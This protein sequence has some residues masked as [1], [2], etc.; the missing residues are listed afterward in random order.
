GRK[1]GPFVTALSAGASDM[2]G[3]LL[4]GLP[5]AMYM[6]D[7]SGSWLAIGLTTGAF[8]N[9]IILAPRL[10]V[11]TDVAKNA[12]ALTVVGDTRFLDKSQLSEL[13]CCV[14]IRGFCT[15]YGSVGMVSGGGLF[16]SALGMDYTIGLGVTSLGVV[17]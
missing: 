17:I 13:V 2:S 9:Y 15:L 1:M 4:M 3:W 7:L 16:E 12:I 10:R 11:Y 5:G 14:S 8:L 6:M